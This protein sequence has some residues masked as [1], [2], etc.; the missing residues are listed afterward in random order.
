MQKHKNSTDMQKKGLSTLESLTLDASVKVKIVRLKGIEHITAAMN[1]HNGN[2]SLQDAGR[3]LLE[4]RAL[5]TKCNPDSS[6]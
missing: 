1:N 2:P 5:L 6:H 3:A 4:N